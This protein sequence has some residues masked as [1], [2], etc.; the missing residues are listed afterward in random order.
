VGPDGRARVGDSS[1]RSEA[2]TTDLPF[3]VGLPGFGPGAGAAFAMAPPPPAARVATRAPRPGRAVPPLRACVPVPAGTYLLGEGGEARP[4]ALA[5]VQIG[6]W[7]VVNAHMRAFAEATGHPLR[8][9]LASRLQSDQLADHPATEVTFDDALAFCAWAGARLP[10]GAEWEAAARGDDGRA[11]P[12]GPTFDH[13]LCACAEAGC[14]WTVAVTAHPG[15]ASP[16]GAE[17]LAGNVWEWVADPPDEDGWRAVRGGSYLD[18]AWGVRAARTLAADPAR[19]T[20][21]TGLRIAID[22]DHQPRREP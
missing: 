2:I 8:P 12:W 1:R 10:T 15:G 13:D 9:A 19:P 3:G 17:Q 14:G 6:Q 4:V 20:A 21:T 11:W 18:H 7:P 22:S 5:G 16:C